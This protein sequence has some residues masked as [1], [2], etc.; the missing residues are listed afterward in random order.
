MF[1]FN[2]IIFMFPLHSLVVSQNELQPRPLP[3]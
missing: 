2:N 1:F 3:T